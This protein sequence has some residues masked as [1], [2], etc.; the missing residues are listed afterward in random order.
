MN[1]GVTLCSI[2][3]RREDHKNIQF[4]SNVRSHTGWV[5][6]CLTRVFVFS[7]TIF[8]YL[9]FKCIFIDMNISNTCT[10][11]FLLHGNLVQDLLI[12]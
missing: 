12:L 3:L 1:E 10:S 2:L 11:T 4:N 7:F 6:V 5:C 9:Y 8:E